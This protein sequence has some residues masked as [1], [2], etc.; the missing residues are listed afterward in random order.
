MDW[1]FTQQKILE[2]KWF[3]FTPT[4]L[5]IKN[6]KLLETNEYELRYEDIGTIKVESSEGKSYLLTPGIFLILVSIFILYLDIS[7]GSNYDYISDLF[8]LTISIAGIAAYLI[9]FNKK[10]VLANSGNINPIYFLKIKSD[11]IALNDFIAK[12]VAKRKSY[13]LEKYGTLNEKLSYEHQFINLKLLL[14]NNTLDRSE[15]DEKLMELEEL[16]QPTS[17]LRRF[18]FCSN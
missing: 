6:R 11:K 18:S 12:I 5:R 15:Y 8:Y 1:D 14:N 4:G 13:L 7:R 2:K 3:K 16:F 9:T 17:V 10:V